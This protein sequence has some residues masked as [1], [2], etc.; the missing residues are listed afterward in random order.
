MIAVTSTSIPSHL[1]C[2]A[3]ASKVLLGDVMTPIKRAA[4]LIGPTRAPGAVVVLTIMNYCSKI[5][6]S[7]SRYTVA[8]HSRF[9]AR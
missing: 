3:M 2:A 4:R 5:N 9:H 1:G 8:G 6:R 7:V